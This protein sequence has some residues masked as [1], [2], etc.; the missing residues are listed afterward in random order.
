[1]K[2]SSTVAIAIVLLLAT[3]G[4]ALAE[5]AGT[6]ADADV[7]C[8]AIFKAKAAADK[9]ISSQQLARDLNLPLEQVNTC[10]RRLRHTGPQA[11]PQA[12]K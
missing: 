12:G 8:N 11:T 1:M 3:S 7:D 5:Q 2:K 9:N 6:A 4:L 10:L